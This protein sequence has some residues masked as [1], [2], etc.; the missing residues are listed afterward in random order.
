MTTSGT[1]TFNSTL[2]D[3]IKDALILLNV[4]GAGEIVSAEDGSLASRVLNRMVKAWQAQGNHIWKKKTATI[5]LQKNQAEYEIS[6][7]GDHA[8]ES[9][10][11][12]TL[13]A[14]EALGQTT[15]SI[16]S[17]AG[18]TAADYIGIELDD[19]SLF[20]STIA[21]VP[22]TTSV[23]ID[24]P[25]PSAASSA[26]KVYAYTTRIEEPFNVYSAVRESVSQI[27]TPLGNFSYEDYFQQ[28]N[29]TSVGVPTQYNYDRQLGAGFIRIWPV[30]GNV[31]TLLKITYAAK[32]EDFNV[33]SN[34]PDFPQEWEESLVLNLA[35]RLAPSFGKT[36]TASYP[37]L[38]QQAQAA[39]LQASSFDNERGSLFMQPNFEGERYA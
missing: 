33:A 4:T 18:M 24:D 1:T 17:S 31:N 11:E 38:M 34:T 26:L 27:D 3:I 16:T 7:N 37:A 32:I 28:P 23:I 9:Y 19:N 35:V 6:L 8:T 36:E 39:L 14:D 13:S 22:D 29:K 15:L 20:W 21:S 10:V 2:N 25:L 5:F 30:P 12:T